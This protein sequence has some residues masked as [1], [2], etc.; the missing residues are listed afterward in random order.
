MPSSVHPSKDRPLNLR[1]KSETE[2]DSIETESE[3]KEA[4]IEEILIFEEVE[5][6]LCEYLLQHISSSDV[7]CLARLLGTGSRTFHIYLCEYYTFILSELY[8]YSL[9]Y[10]VILSYRICI[11]LWNI[12]IYIHIHIY[13]YVCIYIHIYKY[14]YI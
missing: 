6:S 14:E 4:V 11:A 8:C 1:E 13:I 12:Y 9:L 2:S 5:I 10:A 3:E 7:D